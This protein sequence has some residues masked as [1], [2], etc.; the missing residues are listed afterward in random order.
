MEIKQFPELVTP[1]AADIFPLSHNGNV[2][3]IKYS[4]L[5]AYISGLTG[6]V[7]R[8]TLAAVDL[9]TVTQDGIYALQ[10]GVSYTH[11][12][13]GATY[14]ALY[15]FTPY[16][17]TK[18]DIA[19]LLVSGSRQAW[20][21]FYGQTRWSDWAS[22]VTKHD[23]TTLTEYKGIA[24]SAYNRG[25][26]VTVRGTSEGISEAMTTNAAMETIGTL[27]AGYRPPVT[28]T[29]YHQ[30]NA[31]TRVQMI[32]Y[33]SGIIQLGRA[34]TTDG[35]GTNLEAGAYVRFLFSFPEA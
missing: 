31:T 7:R 22:I 30:I 19:Q 34:R 1:S 15:V 10:G 23:D 6:A 16:T 17:S 13:D 24:L 20:I 27:P 35:S 11:M 5:S 9:D 12:P 3:G 29:Q 33:S 4:N 14:G 32:V 18:A 8:G 25:G 26:I 2:F 21:R 28:M